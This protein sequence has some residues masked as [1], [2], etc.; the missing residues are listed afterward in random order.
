[1][2]QVN[3]RLLVGG[4][5]VCRKRLS[6][7]HHFHR[8]PGVVACSLICKASLCQP[9]L[10]WCGKQYLVWASSLCVGERCKNQLILWWAPF[11]TSVLSDQ[12]R[13]HN[14]SLWKHSNVRLFKV[15]I[16]VIKLTSF[17]GTNQS[18]NPPFLSR[19]ANN[20]LLFATHHSK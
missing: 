8:T 9:M 18:F 10:W 5:F 14:H 2:S 13:F 11:D 20:R 15:L 7:V 16:D 1:M 3:S 4:P 19:K 6:V 17:S 12:W